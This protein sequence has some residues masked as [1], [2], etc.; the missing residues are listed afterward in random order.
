MK[1]E[2]EYYAFI[3]YK[4]EDEKWAKWLAHQLDNYKLPSTF[5]GK[6]LPPSLRKTFRDVDEL[7]AGNLPEQIY[8][9]LSMSDNLIVVCSPRAAQSEWVNKEIEDFIKIK[10][11][12]ANRIFP[13]IIEG[14]PFS[15]DGTKECFPQRLRTLPKNEERLGGNINEQGGRNAAVVK[16]VA[17]MLGVS[18]DSLWNR[19]EREQKRRRWMW[20]GI[21]VVLGLI[22]LCIG[23]YFVSQNKII[24]SQNVQLQ[25]LVRN[26]EEENNTYS[27]LEGDKKRYVLAGQVRGNG[28]DDLT[29][30]LYDY[31]PYE[32]IVAF[33][34]DWGVWLHYLNSN[35]EVL[36]PTNSGKEPVYD[37]T[38]I[39]F[40]ADG[41]KLM[42][43]GYGLYI[44]D[45]ETYKLLAH[46]PWG[47]DGYKDSS[48]FKKRFPYFDDVEDSN[49]TDYR[50]ENFR[51]EYQDGKLNIFKKTTKELICFTEMGT[52]A[53]STF[54]E[55]TTLKNPVYN[56]TLFAS[57]ERAALYDEDKQEFVLFFKGFNSNWNIEFSPSGE[58]IRVDKN[59]YARN[60]KADTIRQLKYTTHP[61][62]EYPQFEKEKDYKYDNYN[63]AHL[64]TRENTIIYKCVGFTKEIEALRIYTMGNLHDD[65]FD[66]VFAG[67]NKIVAV[68]RFGNHK[69]YSTKTWNLIGTLGDGLWE[70]FIGH[71]EVLDSREKF[72][73]SIK[74][75][76]R[77]LYIVSSGSVIRIY[78]VD[79]CRIDCVIELPVE[80]HGE[81]YVGCID[82][83]YLADD[84]SEIYYSFGEQS[85]FY[86]CVLPQLK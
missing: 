2:K 6:D 52:N 14:E 73:L 46:Y 59:I 67:P 19:Y 8:K 65:L 40:S 30:M 57:V 41:K 62:E 34:D 29:L 60:I 5:N 37:I 49:I 20:T 36:L 79:K 51:Y 33:S 42:A 85:I 13:F 43:E 35:V 11:D 16:V 68:L 4:R 74:Y 71:E 12:K 78:D 1:Q 64:D 31:H 22:G 86:H 10:G 81:E 75:I 77:K 84:G 18:F 38:E 48:E 3:S 25:N 82:K 21:A 32:P 56:E 9:A 69:I 15:N 58:Y 53:D 7:S 39:H 80:N 54:S 27:Q 76:N 23:A 70:D 28:C 83:V 47:E 50:P 55:L 63:N 24:E 45:V 44:W 26:L 17:G 66:A 72:P 61:I